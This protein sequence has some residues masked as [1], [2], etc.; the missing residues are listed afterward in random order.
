MVCSSLSFS[1][2]N[3]MPTKRISTLV[4]MIAS[5]AFVAAAQSGTVKRVISKSDDFDFG[6]GGTITVTGAPKGSVRIEGTRQN[7]VEIDA[8]I[9]IEAANE[10]DLTALQNVTGFVLDQSTGR[11][12]ITSVGTND[13]KYLKQVAKKFPKRLVGLPFSIDYVLK[14]PR[15]CDLQVNNGSGDVVISGI[16]GALSVN[17]LE[18]NIKLDLVSGGLTATFGKGN[19]FITMPERG[20]GGRPIDAALASGE[21]NVVLPVNLSAEL[22][23]TDLR[24]GK[25]ENE[26]TDLK[27]R[28]RTVKFTEQSISAR[29]GSGGTPLKFT[30]GDGTIRLKTIG[31]E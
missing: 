2:D 3:T 12:T 29:A 19:V 17:S 8:E 11:V 20:W 13:S 30:V 7:T 1:S 6:A 4:L 18:G 27:P 24:T 5:C 31:N 23:V 22:Y 26:L 25:I 16:E 14:V 15:Y 10:T 9:T 28:V 21:M